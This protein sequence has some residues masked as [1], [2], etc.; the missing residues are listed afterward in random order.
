[1]NS[2]QAI[3]AATVN[4]KDVTLQDLLF[5]LKINDRLGPLRDAVDDVVIMEAAK[6]EGIS[7]AD[8]ELQREADALRRGLGLDKAAETKKWLSE[9]GMGVDELETYLTRMISA[10]KLKDRVTRDR[11]EGYFAEHRPSFD[12]ARLSQ[13]VVRDAEL[14]AEVAEKARAAHTEFEHLVADFSVDARGRANDGRVGWVRRHDMNPRIA[15]VVFSAK[16]GDVVGPIAIAGNQV[17]IRVERIRRAQL[18][19]ETRGIIRDRLFNDWLKNATASAGV[20]FA[21]PG[22]IQSH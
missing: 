12:S 20:D 18:D 19:D 10:S 16:N 9:R 21:L 4:G 3:T 8:D 17:V 2:L 11:I 6:S 13:I 1:M 5:S 15:E 7:V 14:A 22:L